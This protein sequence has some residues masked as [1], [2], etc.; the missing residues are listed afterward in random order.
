MIKQFYRWLIEIIFICL[1]F[2]DLFGVSELRYFD[3]II[4]ILFFFL[5]IIDFIKK[6]GNIKNKQTKNI[7]I[8]M[9]GIACIGLAGNLINPIQQN[10][11][12]ATIG[13]FITLKQYIC[14]LYM[15]L[16]LN[17]IYDYKLYSFFL[18][19]SKIMLSMLLF[20]TCINSIV[21]I[22]MSG[23]SGEFCFFSQFGGTVACW[24]ILFLSF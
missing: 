13:M 16:C 18:K 22:G 4:G 14:G 9:I 7:L 5:I 23:P 17:K 3:E 11:T 12:I 21:N 6:K 8:C 15:L 24:T 2:S 10:I 19:V 20:C 1:M